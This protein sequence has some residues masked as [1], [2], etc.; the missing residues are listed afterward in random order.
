MRETR[1]NIQNT[2]KNSSVIMGAIL[3][4]WYLE[5]V[6]LCENGVIFEQTEVRR[7]RSSKHTR[8]RVI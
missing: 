2:Y 6:F 7:Q 8:V 3:R 5:V 1:V 4:P